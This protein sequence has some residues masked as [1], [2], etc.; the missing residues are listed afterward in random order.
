MT[1]QGQAKRT[2]TMSNRPHSK[3]TLPD[4]IL[5]CLCRGYVKDEEIAQQQINEI[6]PVYFIE[7]L[8]PGMSP[9]KYKSFVSWL[10]R[11][12][13]SGKD[14][15][16]VALEGSWKIK[17]PEIL[18]PGNPGF[19]DTSVGVE[20]KKKKTASTRKID[21]GKPTEPSQKTN[22]NS[23]TE[24]GKKNTKLTA[25]VKYADQD[26]QEIQF[27]LKFTKNQ[28][29]GTIKNFLL[30]KLGVPSLTIVIRDR[31][32]PADETLAHQAGL[33]EGTTITLSDIPWD[34]E[35]FITIR[36]Q[37]PNRTTVWSK[38]FRKSESALNIPWRFSVACHI[39][40]KNLVIHRSNRT[41]LNLSATIRDLEIREGEI[42][43]AEQHDGFELRVHWMEEGKQQKTL[44]IGSQWSDT[45]VHRYI[46][47]ALGLQFKF[48]MTTSKGEPSTGH[49]ISH[50]HGE[51]TAL[52][53][54]DIYL[55][56]P[57]QT[58]WEEGVVLTRADHHAFVDIAN[59]GTVGIHDDCRESYVMDL[60]KMLSEQNEDL[61]GRVLVDF[62]RLKYLPHER[63]TDIT[64]AEISTQLYL[65]EE[66]YTEEEITQ[67]LK[68]IALQLETQ[69]EDLLENKYPFLK[70]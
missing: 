69:P 25:T 21:E 3:G 41:P 13:K 40:R 22:T 23:S 32:T 42:L 55:L 17:V 44:W 2:K 45:K 28:K 57:S 63:I 33:I 47:G 19:V 35:D 4:Y 60:L 24:T 52:K 39:N 10:D 20:N 49:D 59:D 54:L 34:K 53:D 37:M 58:N 9:A 64:E 18:K 14:E 36:I 56:L 15:S 43:Q 51:E 46:A 27:P 11:R 38:Q 7:T 1:N 65:V 66:R 6:T 16:I 62:H 31:S 70:P 67:S 5:Y 29:M 8:K 50:P 68:E 12:E 61:R 26:D 30:K 48:K